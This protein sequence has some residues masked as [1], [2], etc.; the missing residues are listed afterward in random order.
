MSRRSSRQIEPIG[1]VVQREATFR[2]EASKRA[3][4][5]APRDW[6]SAVGTRIAA[7]A[8]PVKLDR[9][10]LLVRTASATGAQ[11][12]TPL[13]DAIIEQ[14]RAH[15]VA[16][17][18]LRFLVGAVDPPER[19]PWRQEVRTSPPESPLPSEVKRELAKVNDPE[20]R[21]A[22]ARAASKNLGWQAHRE[23]VRVRPREDA[24]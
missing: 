14:L 12:L 18:S 6:E 4:P 22:I 21:A 10:V 3:P 7:R 23:V 8:R 15:R 17:D 11:E 1:A 20:L 5:V 19:P 9:G 16:V 2:V 13:A 24:A